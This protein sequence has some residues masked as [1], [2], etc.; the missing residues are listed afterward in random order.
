MGELRHTSA[1]C[2][3][4]YPHPNPPRLGEGTRKP[5]RPPSR[6][7]ANVDNKFS[8]VYVY[9][10]KSALTINC[11]YLQRN[12]H[13]TLNDRRPRTRRRLW[14]GRQWQCP[15]RKRSKYSRSIGSTAQCRRKTYANSRALFRKRTPHRP[16]RSAHGRP[17]RCKT[18]PHAWQT[19]VRN[20]H[21]FR[22]TT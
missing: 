18:S 11:L 16:D 22:V 1:L 17:H 10:S 13:R 12:P 9:T 15:R 3:R 4:R 21:R 20:R 8:L 6:E 5:A 2:V 19:S 14:L 7:S